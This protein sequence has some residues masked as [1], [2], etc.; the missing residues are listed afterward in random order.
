MSQESED[1]VLEWPLDSILIGSRDQTTSL[2]AAQELEAFL[3]KQR[4]VV[5][6]AYASGLELTADQMA[7]HLSLSV[8]TVQ[9][10]VSELYHAGYLWRTGRTVRSTA[11][12]RRAHIYTVAK[13][14]GI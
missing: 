8:R 5:Y 9:P 6:A 14:R 11:T 3:T 13:R 4:R 2:Y 7:V 12:G 10:R 1:S